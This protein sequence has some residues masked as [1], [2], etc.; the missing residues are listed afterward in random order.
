MQALKRLLKPAFLKELLTRAL[1]LAPA[2]TFLAVSR[3]GVHLAEAGPAETSASSFDRTLR[4]DLCLGGDCPGQLAV[5]PRPGAPAGEITLLKNL[6]QFLAATLTA[7]ME[8]ESAKRQVVA[9]TLDKYREIE[10][11]H[12]GSLSLN[13]SLRIRDVAA[14]LLAECQW[15]PSARPKPP[16]SPGWPKAACSPRSLPAPRPRSST[17]SPPIPAGRTRS[18]R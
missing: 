15:T 2:G 3:N 6:G 16:G 9:E 17:T 13:R 18:R 11:L 1:P 10:L 4:F 12:R 5:H 7:T 14:A 8:Q